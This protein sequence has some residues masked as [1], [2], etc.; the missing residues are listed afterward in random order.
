MFDAFI[1]C[2][3]L[4]S[5]SAAMLRLLSKSLD[6]WLYSWLS[7][8]SLPPTL[9]TWIGSIGSLLALLSFHGTRIFPHTERGR[10]ATESCELLVA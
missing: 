5:L 3:G 6:I 9:L 10:S 2:G 4:C 7:C 8:S 1:V